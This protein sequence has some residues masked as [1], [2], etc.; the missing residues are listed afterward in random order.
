M[1]KSDKAAIAFFLAYLL[2]AG[3]LALFVL[4]RETQGK[5]AWERFAAEQC[6]VT[7]NYDRDSGQVRGG[8]ID[9]DDPGPKV[10]HC[11]DGSMH[12]R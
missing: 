8:V 4:H 11:K 10:Y 3:A 12:V 5:E 9:F 6:R 2:I 7:G 1:S